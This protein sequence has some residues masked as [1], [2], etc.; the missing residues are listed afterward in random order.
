MGSAD[1]RQDCYDRGPSQWAR[2]SPAF[3][4]FGRFGAASPTE[5]LRH[6]GGLLRRSARR[7]RRREESPNSAGQCAG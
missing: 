4:S 1:C 3:A 7:A 6:S 2:R 5:P